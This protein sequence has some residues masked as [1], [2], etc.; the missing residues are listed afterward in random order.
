MALAT[1]ACNFCAGD[2]TIT[3]GAL[4][5]ALKLYATELAADGTD[6]YSGIDMK[7]GINTDALCA[8]AE[9]QWN[10][11]TMQ[12]TEIFFMAQLKNFLFLAC[13]L[14]PIEHRRPSSFVR[15]LCWTPEEGT[16][17]KAT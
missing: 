2:D 16:S 17:L 3:V 15:W 13:C 4:A 7:V 9:H 5:G 12:G 6:C 11:N 1:R 8:K 10:P 14:D